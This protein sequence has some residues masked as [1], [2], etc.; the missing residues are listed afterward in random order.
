MRLEASCA[1]LFLAASTAGQVV[2]NL[3]ELKCEGTFTGSAESTCQKV[4]AVLDAQP[5][6]M[7]EACRKD[8]MGSSFEHLNLLSYSSGHLI[9]AIAIMQGAL[10][11]TNK[12]AEDVK[13]LSQLH[14]IDRG[15]PAG[16]NDVE[17]AHYCLGLAPM[18][19]SLGLCLPQSCDAVFIQGVMKGLTSPPTPPGPPSAGALGK[20]GP[21]ETPPLAFSC[22]D[23]LRVRVNTGS[24][25]VFCMMACLV[26]LVALGT[27]ID[28]HHRLQKKQQQQQ[29]KLQH[30]HDLGDKSINTT[31]T[32]AA[33]KGNGSTTTTAWVSSSEHQGNGIEEAKDE[34][35]GEEAA[36]VTRNG[37]LLSNGGSG[38]ELRQPLL[39]EVNHERTRS[40]AVS[41]ADSK[42]A[43]Y[44][45]GLR[46]PLVPPPEMA[47]SQSIEDRL[48]VEEARYGQQ[49]EYGL[50]GAD[51]AL[52]QRQRW[53]RCG[54]WCGEH[55]E[56][57]SLMVNVGSLLAPPRAGDEFPALD[58]VRTMSMLWVVLGHTFSYNVTGD[59]PGFAN[60]IQVVPQ[61]GNGLL[62]RWT[63][64]VIP[65][66][67][68]AVDTFFLMSGFLL[69]SVLL[70]KLDSGS[71]GSG[72][73]WI[74][75]AY[76][77]R[78]LRLTPT[79]AFVML[80]FWKVLPLLGDGPG[81][82]PVAN[83]Q[84]ESCYKWWWA[85]VTYLSSIA[86]WPPLSDGC[87]RVSWYLSNDT[88]FFLAAVPLI[89]LYHRRPQMGATIAFCVALASCLFTFLWYGFRD[90]VRFPYLI[91]NQDEQGWNTAYASPWGRC[92]PYIV[93]VLCGMVWH[94][95]F[96]GRV[97]PTPRDASPDAEAI[98]AA[99]RRKTPLERFGMIGSYPAAVWAVGLV[100]GA[101]MA[102]PVYGTYWAYQDAD[103]SGVSPWADHLYLAFSRPAWALGVAL[104]CLLCFCGYGGLVNWVLTRP[105]WT[106]PSRLTYCA[107]LFHTGLL[108]VLYGSRDLAVELTGLE[109]AVTYMGVVLGTFAG[110]TLLHLLV[111]APFRNLESM[112][113]RQK[114]KMLRARERK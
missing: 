60:T 114:Q 83:A 53:W 28:Y 80:M 59:G 54:R 94:T 78:Y 113:R 85:E 77:H 70:P 106:T 110:A 101:L 57:F 67:F 93:G 15:S 19:A 107:Y 44:L 56:C 76:L 50:S 109:Y 14:V 63:A 68:L 8:L 66:G 34:P 86:P 12:S 104:M 58:G 27:Y 32:T 35:K 112:G 108:K 18:A 29:L 11:G 33:T 79:L 84:E 37:E 103:N 25:A 97:V 61:H 41:S 90:D 40:A 21:T 31:T 102:L 24:V 3:C 98:A 46:Q 111:E 105:G 49:Q 52:A 9:E 72:R 6:E 16:C 71:L 7:A 2:D 36:F 64:Q 65:G 26:G 82:W 43:W 20:K 73:S 22:G 17:G 81:W 62:S 4:C 89:S 13:F 74:G 10:P 51:R 1:L 99:S 45:A 23:E 75:K 47:V 100:S 91:A 92:S 5:G 55:L 69:S 87:T 42:L 96:R 39:S 30:H 38:E 95:E 88:I 48:S